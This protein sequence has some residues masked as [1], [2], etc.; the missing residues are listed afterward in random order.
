MDNVFKLLFSMKRA[1]SLPLALLSWVKL[2]KLFRS[3]VNRLLSTWY[4][5]SRPSIPAYLKIF[6]EVLC[7]VLII[8]VIN[9][10]LP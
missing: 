1:R 5:E 2:G 3:F 9:V 7:I 6:E 10:S 4:F 8:I